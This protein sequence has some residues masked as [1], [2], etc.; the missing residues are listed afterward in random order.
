[1][2]YA[3]EKNVFLKQQQQKILPFSQLLRPSL[4]EFNL[5]AHYNVPP[6]KLSVLL[7]I[8]MQNNWIR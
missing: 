6:F 3:E 2:F 8:H 4:N 1:M 7:K 5:I